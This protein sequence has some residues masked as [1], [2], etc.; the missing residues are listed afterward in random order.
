MESAGENNGSWS[1][2]ADEGAGAGLA[3]S[4]VAANGAVGAVDTVGNPEVGFG[5]GNC[6]IVSRTAS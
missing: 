6:E 2:G 5:V 3:D 1:V 4:V